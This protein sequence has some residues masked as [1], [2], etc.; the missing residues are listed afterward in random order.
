LVKD[1]APPLS[2]AVIGVGHF[3]QHHAGKFACLTGSR[4]VAVADTDP[5]RRVSIASRYAVEPVGDYR[6]LL[7]RVDAVSIATPPSSHFEIAQDFIE[8]GSHVLVEKPITE[9]VED[10]S[11]LIR[12]A[13]DR[14]KVLQVGHIE[15]FSAVG[16]RFG[17]LIHR[18]LFVQAQRMGP[19]KP[20]GEPVS[21][22]LD[23]MIHDLDL[24]LSFVR[25]PIEWAHA[26]GA[27]VLTTADDIAS[28]RIQFESGCIADLTVSRI[29][30]RS[31]RKMRIFQKHSCT[32]VDFLKR[33]ITVFERD[34]STGNGAPAIKLEEKVYPH[35]DALEEEVA[36]FLAAARGD[37]P[38]VVTGEDGRRALEAALLVDE[39]LRRN[40]R[41]LAALGE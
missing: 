11:R 25:S 35:I 24:I 9:S 30:L 17:E 14:G 29:S 28:C 26:I 5:E 2:T 41:R 34:F 32:S 15:R 3:G 40:W 8:H 4:L 19:F 20:R 27:P 18:P 23:L 39:Q 38:P 22:V 31:E 21:A 37:C 33:R 16:R 13:K 10:A 6:T 1:M 12:L 36:A 7:G